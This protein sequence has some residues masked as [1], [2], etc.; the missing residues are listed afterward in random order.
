MNFLARTVIFVIGISSC[1][2]ILEVSSQAPSVVELCT[3]NGCLRGRTESGNVK[4][5]NAFYGIPFAAPPIGS[6]RFKVSLFRR[7]IIAT[8]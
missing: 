3:S 6:L 2:L 4:P 7:Q 1:A 8:K 5:Y